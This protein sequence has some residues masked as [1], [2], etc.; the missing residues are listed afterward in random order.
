MNDFAD[1]PSAAVVRTLVPA[2]GV[3]E[4]PVVYPSLCGGPGDPYMSPGVVVGV[5]HEAVVIDRPAFAGRGDDGT[6]RVRAAV[7]GIPQNS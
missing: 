3:V 6:R 5:Y 2:A 4:I 7:N 1:G